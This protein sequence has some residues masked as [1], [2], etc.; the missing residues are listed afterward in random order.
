VLAG[1]A[2]AAARCAWAALDRPL[3]LYSLGAG[4][5]L[6]RDVLARGGGG[7]DCR[8]ALRELDECE[9]EGEGEGEEEGE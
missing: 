7:A 2:P 8:R 6:A 5:A 9:C 1:D 3:G 4:L